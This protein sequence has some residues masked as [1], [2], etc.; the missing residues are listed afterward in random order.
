VTGFGLV[1][2][3]F[4]MAK[5]SGVA[6]EIDSAALPALPEAERLAAAGNVTRG[7]RDNRAYL[8]DALLVAPDVT[9]TRMN[10][11]LDPQTSGGLAV[12]VAEDALPR[13][14]DELAARNVPTRAVI[15]RTL[16]SK[17]PVLRIQ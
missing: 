4:Q 5:A 7:D 14:L 10:L 17:H 2:H 11:L 12:C 6:L 9:P 16:A 15:G 13:L 1:G 8:G 3:L